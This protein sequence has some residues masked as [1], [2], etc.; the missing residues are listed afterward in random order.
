MIFTTNFVT[1]EQMHVPELYNHKRLGE[2]AECGPLVCCTMAWVPVRR[3]NTHSLRTQMQTPS[4][5]I[6]ATWTETHFLGC[7]IST[8]QHAP[9]RFSKEEN[10][11]GE[12]SGPLKRLESFGNRLP[13]GKEVALNSDS[14]LT[15]GARMV[16]QSICGH[17]FP[18]TMTSQ[19]VYLKVRS[20]HIYLFGDRLGQRLLS[21]SVRNTIVNT[22]KSHTLRWTR[23]LSI[24]ISNW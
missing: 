11:S 22:K 19:H 17:H 10:C 4:W 16:T 7:V 15:G 6:R 20:V 1:T 21:D 24:F 14:L 8:F 13:A 9:R 3:A 12:P 23:K 2:V 18:C 5:T